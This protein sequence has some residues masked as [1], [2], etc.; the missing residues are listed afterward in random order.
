LA[1]ALLRIATRGANAAHVAGSAASG[2]AWCEIHVGRPDQTDG[3]GQRKQRRPTQ[4]ADVQKG[5]PA[6]AQAHAGRVRILG[7]LLRRG[8]GRAAG[9]IGGAGA[10]ERLLQRLSAGAD[11]DRLD[12]GE[13]NLLSD[14]RRQMLALRADPR[15]ALERRLRPRH[16]RFGPCVGRLMVDEGADR[17]QLG[18]LGD[19]AD[20]I[21]VKVRHQQIVDAFDARGTC[22]REDPVGVARLARIAGQRRERAGL[23]GKAGVDQQRL[24]RWRDDQRGLAALDV[25]EIDVQRA[26]QVRGHRRREAEQRDDDK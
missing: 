10:G 13:R 16:L 5:E 3:T 26:A 21:G 1:A 20:M 6:V 15:V 23:A 8:S 24:P 14:L 19:A 9:R 25:D 7:R 22:R 12:A 4:I 2:P 18:E 11:N 17:D